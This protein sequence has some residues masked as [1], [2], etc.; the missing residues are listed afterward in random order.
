MILPIY[1]YGHPVLRKIA[2]DID[3]DYEGLEKLLK[4]MWQTMY[5]TD[6]VGLAAPQIG[7]SI[8]LFVIDADPF[9]DIDP[10]AEGFKRTF[11]N[12]EITER[13]GEAWI[14]NEGCLSI[15]LIHEDVKRD[16]TIHIK[17]YDENWEL[18]EEDFNGHLA[19][20]IQHEY[21]H[22]EG[23]MFIDHISGLKKRLLK[24]KLAQIS[25]GKSRCGYRVVTPK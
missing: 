23:K 15:P 4:D 25:K 3:K 7:K 19:R 9:Q 1:V 24:G 17:Y 21:D 6:G 8:R 14:M 20:V 2:Q 13:G 11:I 10:K 16:E 18:H 22:L 12:A 5:E